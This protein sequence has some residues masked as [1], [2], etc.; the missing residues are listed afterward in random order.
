MFHY[1]PHAASSRSR[2][3]WAQLHNRWVVD[4]LN[5]REEP[6]AYN[7]VVSTASDVVA[8]LWGQGTPAASATLHQADH[9]SLIAWGGSCTVESL[10]DELDELGSHG[11]YQ[12]A[13]IRH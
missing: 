10:K 8:G 2:Q 4:A 3:S 7:K 5:L 11:G 13:E 12:S 9:F 1:R 6:V